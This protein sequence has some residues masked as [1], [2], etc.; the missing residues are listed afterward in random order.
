MI[1]VECTFK[2]FRSLEDRLS[3]GNGGFCAAL[4]PLTAVSAWDRGGVRATYC[5]TRG[6]TCL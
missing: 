6:Q 2:V 5:R 3:E 4:L 1:V